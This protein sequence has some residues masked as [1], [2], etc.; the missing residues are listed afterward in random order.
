MS[1]WG[2][3]VHRA[4]AQRAS[5]LLDAKNADQMIRALSEFETY[6]IVKELGMADAAPVLALLQPEQVRAL[7]DLDTWRDHRLDTT[8]LLT[9]FQGF[10]EAGSVDR[11]AAALDLE[12]LATLFKRRLLIAEKP[13]DDRSDPPPLPEWLQSPSPDLGPLVE[14]HDGRFIVAARPVDEKDELEDS[15]HRKIDEEERKAIMAI[16]DALY[17]HEGWERISHALSLAMTDFSSDLEET[18]YQFRN[19]RLE[20]YGFA[21]LERAI[22]VYAPLDSLST[23]GEYPQVD[24]Q[25]PALHAQTLATGLFDEAMN[26]IEDESIVRRIEGDLVPLA[27]LVLI[28]DRVEPGAIEAVR[29][30]LVRMKG[31]LEIALGDAGADMVSVLRNTPVRDLFRFGYTK[32]LKLK[33]RASKLSRDPKFER[34]PELERSA[35]AP[36]RLT[37]PMMSAALDAVARS[38]GAPEPLWSPGLDPIG[39]EAVRSFGSLQDIQ[40][41]ELLLSQAERMFDALET[42]GWAAPIEGPVWP[43]NPMEHTWDRVFATVCARVVLGQEASPAPLSAQDLATLAD[44]LAMSH[45]KTEA[46]YRFGPSVESA[47][48]DA[49]LHDGA[50][51]GLRQGL[52]QL[53]EVLWPLVG[54]SE[55]DPRFVDVVLRRPG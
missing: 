25:L 43:E 55:I 3:T 6:Y 35:L 10:A 7:L 28:A 27:N 22:E 32:T 29:E 41:A 34:L 9:W 49:G 26:R 30:S 45:E 52:V 1:I 31:Y 2:L 47:V 15:D 50:R 13:K 24:L 4:K 18:S 44:R 53:A 12:V 37:R 38:I 46:G 51:L 20:D 16:L 33:T 39:A 40:A 23:V 5:A 42:L 21:P 8:E 54:E 11:A 17:K 14:T 19:A 36:L 48:L